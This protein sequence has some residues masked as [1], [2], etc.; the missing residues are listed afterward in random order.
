V[1]RP[2]AA[3]ERAALSTWLRPTTGGEP[4]AV[5]PPALPA[6]A[7]RRPRRRRRRVDDQALRRWLAAGPGEA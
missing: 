2:S 4:R 6:Q 3:T 5:A 1:P 7:P